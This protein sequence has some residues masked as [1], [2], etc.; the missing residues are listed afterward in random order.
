MNDNFTIAR[1][2]LASFSKRVAIRRCSLSHPTIRSTTLR[3]RLVAPQKVGGRPRRLR[4]LPAGTR[5]SGVSSEGTRIIA[6]IR[7]HQLRAAAY[8]TAS[9]AGG[10]PHACQQFCADGAL[11]LLS[12]RKEHRQGVA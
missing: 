5:F 6:S 9:R 12:R 10:Y 3:C 1:K 4:R 8:S 7:H 11:V 2:L